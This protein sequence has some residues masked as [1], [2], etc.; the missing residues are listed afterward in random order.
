MSAPNL[1]LIDGHSLAFRA[2]YAFSK[3]RDGGLRT[4]TGIPTSV[5]FGFLKT[6]L[7]IL[8]Q[9][10]ANHVAIA[11]DLGEPTFR[12]TADENYKA[13][14]AETPQDFIADIANLQALLRA[15]RLPLL[16]Q[17]G[18]EA[19]DVIGTVAHR[20]RPEGWQVSIVSGDR[21]LF[22][23]IDR[24]GQVQVLYLGNTLG[25]RKQGLEAFDALKVKEKMGVWPEQIVDYKALCGDASDRI[26]GIKGI[27]PKT[28]VQLLS[29]Y[30][31]LEDIY[32]HINEIT[33]LS[34]RTKLINGEVE[35]RHSRNLAQIVLDVPLELPLEELHLRPF[36][37]PTLDDLLDHLEFRALRMQL[38]NWHL[39]LGGTLP[40]A[41]TEA[42]ETWFFAPTA[43][44]DPL[45]VQ[46]IQT[47]EQL[48]WLIS[49]L[50]KLY[51][52]EPSRGVGH[53]NHGLESPRCYFSG[54][55]LLLGHSAGS[56]G[57]SALGTQRGAEPP[58]AR[59]PR[60]CATPS[61]GRSLPQS[62]AKCQI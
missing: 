19:D 22:Q 4:S 37:W 43:T 53:R 47:P 38:Q 36:D 33:P 7:E 24:E 6:L 28:A 16:S 8:D 26:P 50:K 18:Y 58:P 12:H 29:Q 34:L 62:L 3:G 5:C 41:E 44:P 46:L 51:R 25:Q 10:Q 31:T 52:P 49:Q 60:R 59:D 48:Q 27:G 17:T 15:L 35:A 32:A 40:A 1:L 42:D 61:G 2:Y 13:G 57:L 30:P 55:G 56:G 9:Q 54:L 39:R 21:D 11:F 45:Q 20:L 14:R 23:L